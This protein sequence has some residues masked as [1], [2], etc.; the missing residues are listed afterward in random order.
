MSSL[1]DDGTANLAIASRPDVEVLQNTLRQKSNYLWL[2]RFCE[3]LI[4]LIVAL[5]ASLVVA[6]A[7][8]A[9]RFSMGPPVFFLQER[10][11]LGRA[12]TM[13]KLRT[14]TQVPQTI[15]GLLYPAIDALP[16]L[17]VCF[18]LR[19]LMSFHNCGMSGEAT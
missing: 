13:I 19:I 1:A 4:V 17:G 2:R 16:G 8:I 9:I 12:F 6:I 11:G 18:V 5:P 7:A 3:I 10:V 15:L 14:M